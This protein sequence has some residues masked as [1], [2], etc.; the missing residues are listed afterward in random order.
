MTSDVTGDLTSLQK[1]LYSYDPVGNVL[2]I[3]DYKMGS[4]QTQSFTYDALYRL[5]SAQASGGADGNYGPETYGYNTATGN[6]ASK[7]GL[8]YTYGDPSH[9]HAVTSLSNGWSYVYDPN[10]NMTQRNLGNQAFNLAY[11]AENRLVQVSGTVTATFGYDGDGKRVLATEGVTTTVYLG[12]YFEISVSGGVTSTVKY[13]YAGAERI[14]MRQNEGAVK[15]LLGDHLGSTSLVYD[16]SQTIRQGYKAWGER[17]FILGGEE[18]PTTFR[19]TGQREEASIGLYYYGARWYDPVL[20]RFAQADTIIP[21][22]A[23]PQAWD[24]YSYV[25]NNPIRYKDPNGHKMECAIGFICKAQ[26]LSEENP[27]IP[28]PDSPLDFDHPLPNGQPPPP[29]IEGLPDDQWEWRDNWPGS[30]PGYR[31]KQD[32]TG[33]T[34]RPDGEKTSKSGNE[35]EQPHWHGR[36]PGRRGDVIFPDNYQ[37]GREGQRKYPGDYNPFTRR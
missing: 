33:R 9:A 37:W 32:P 35:G 27:D 17:R 4:P 36:T 8:T 30:G 5:I 6:M 20:G 18:L 11:D 16:G 10:G 23:T 22:T 31:N 15:W 28:L 2:S 24:R 29:H 7:A 19:Y 12:N 3:Q 34:W 13:Y 14:A 21:E 1:L 26:V 25:Y